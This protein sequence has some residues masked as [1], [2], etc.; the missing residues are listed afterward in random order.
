MKGMGQTQKQAQ[1][2][3]LWAP[4]H[5]LGCPGSQQLCSGLF[6]IKERA[7]ADGSHC[8]LAKPQMGKTEGHQSAEV[9]RRP[10]PPLSL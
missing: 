5:C 2:H 8:G 9:P 1:A 10:R 3:Q 6:V 4:A 7:L